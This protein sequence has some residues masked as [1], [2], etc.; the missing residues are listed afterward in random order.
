VFIIH[1]LNGKLGI[2]SEIDCED[3]KCSNQFKIYE[4]K[5]EDH[6]LYLKHNLTCEDSVYYP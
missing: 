6:S 2:C 5:S 1:N 3:P 4:T